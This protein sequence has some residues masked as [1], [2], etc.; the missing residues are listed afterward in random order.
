VSVPVKRPACV[1]FD[2]DETLV[3]YDHSARVRTL[4]ARVGVAP[5][6]IEAELFASGLERDSDLGRHDARSQAEVLARRLGVA[7]SLAD[8]IAARAASMT[9]DAEVV[10]LAHEAAR[11][12]SVAILSNNGL[13]VR[14][15]LPALCPALSP[16]FDGRVLCSAEFGIGKPEAAIF[17]HASARL[18][19]PP[20]A[21]LFVDDKRANADAAQAAG[22]RAHHHRNAAGL[23]AALIDHGLLEN[24]DHAP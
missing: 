17:A 20:E 2:L 16:L 10:A 23:R 21:I 1:L 9:P 19:L 11:H 12:A 3:R 4:A 6:R 15:H 24:P 14:D 5:E 8:C 7:V 18:G 13:L 22:M